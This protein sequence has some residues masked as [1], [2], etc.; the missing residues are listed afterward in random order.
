MARDLNLDPDLTAEEK[1]DVEAEAIR[2]NWKQMGNKTGYW[3]NGDVG[4]I[5]VG[6]LHRHFTDDVRPAA[7]AWKDTNIKEKTRD[8][9]VEMPLYNITDYMQHYAYEYTADLCREFQVKH[10]AYIDGFEM[11][12]KLM[13][14]EGVND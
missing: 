14:E 12:I 2:R 11:A 1:K 6:Q 3:Y 5:P 13:A 4:P 7:T 8:P 10:Q 9:E